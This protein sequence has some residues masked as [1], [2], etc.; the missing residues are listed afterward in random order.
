MKVNILGVKIRR[1]HKVE[2]V[3]FPQ[4]V[5]VGTSPVHTWIGSSSTESLSKTRRDTLTRQNAVD[6]SCGSCASNPFGFIHYYSSSNTGSVGSVVIESGQSSFEKTSAHRSFS[7]T[8]CEDLAHIDEDVCSGMKSKPEHKG[9]CRQIRQSL[10]CMLHSKHFSSPV[11]SSVCFFP[12]SHNQEVSTKD[13]PQEQYSPTTTH[14]SSLDLPAKMIPVPTAMMAEIL[15]NPDL[16]SKVKH[17]ESGGSGKSVESVDT[18]HD[19]PMCRSNDCELLKKQTN[20]DTGVRRSP[21]SKRCYSYQYI[22]ITTNKPKDSSC[23]QYCRDI[24]CSSRS[25]DSGLADIAGNS[26]AMASPDL[27]GLRPRIS[28]FSI[29][30]H[31]FTPRES[32]ELDYE[33][34]CVCTSPF[35]STPRTSAQPSLMSEKIFVDSTESA[36]PSVTSSCLDASPVTTP[37][38]STSGIYRSGMYAHWWLKTKLPL[39]ALR[40]E[41]SPPTGKALLLMFRPA[42]MVSTLFT[43]SVVYSI[44]YK[45]VALIHQFYWLN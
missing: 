15:Y 19:L 7:C 2:Y 38:S 4:R 37:Q 35:G 12:T 30:A 9:P 8:V 13:L 42:A 23:C 26:S 25:S 28:H 10:P 45:Y 27:S 21:K 16:Y 11:S 34:Q 14:S 40:I 24:P 18:V 1:S 29:P 44:C 20:S 31:S 43:L 3:I 39:S 33:A 17:Q 5:S 32:S 41:A 36:S 22:N 6:E